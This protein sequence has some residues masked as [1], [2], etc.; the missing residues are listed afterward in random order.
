MQKETAGIKWVNGK[1]TTVAILNENNNT[2]KMSVIRQKGESQNE[3]NKKIKHAKFSE[4]TNIF[5]TKYAH[6]RG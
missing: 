5:T 6:V 4:K 3:G 1:I 2:I